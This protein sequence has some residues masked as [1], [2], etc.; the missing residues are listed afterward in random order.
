M[1][2]GSVVGQEGAKR[3]PMGGPSVG[4]GDGCERGV[5]DH[6]NSVGSDWSGCVRAR[7]DGGASTAEGRKQSDVRDRVQG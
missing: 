1:N 4:D 7:D 3:S 6:G 5:V 2:V